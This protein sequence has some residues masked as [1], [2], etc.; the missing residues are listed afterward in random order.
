MKYAYFPGCEIPARL[1]EYGIATRAVLDRLGVRL[2]D[3]RFNCCGY[4]VRQRS[5]EASALSGAR[6]LALARREHLSIVTPCK[7]C[8]GN[9]KHAE[10]WMKQSPRLRDRINGILA[11]EG[12]EW[13][14]DVRVIHLLTLLTED[15]GTDMIRSSVTNPLHGLKVAAHYG[16]HALRPDNVV[17][18]DNPLA[19]TIF[20]KLIAA[21]G[22]EPVNWPLRLECCGNPL[23]EK[24]SRLSIKLMN[25]KI[26]NA[27]ESGADVLATACTHCQIQFDKIRNSLPEKERKYPELESVLYIQ[28]LGMSM[29]LEA[30]QIRLSSDFS[31]SG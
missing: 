23:W 12:L 21:I 26:A 10:Y 5:F 13:K 20:E 27:Y 11:E 14:E 6:N 24:N 29:G 9:L 2:I 4:P 18:F 17:Q 8:Y 3:L 1:P 15:I 30:G 7:C 28:M 19:P 25:R 16:C 31:I 22:A